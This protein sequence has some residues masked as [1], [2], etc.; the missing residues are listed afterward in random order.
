MGTLQSETKLKRLA[1]RFQ[2]QTNEACMRIHEAQQSLLQKDR[3][4]KAAERQMVGRRIHKAKSGVRRL[5]AFGNSRSL[6]QI[7]KA[8]DRLPGRGSGVLFSGIDWTWIGNK[9]MT[10]ISFIFQHDGMKIT[11]VNKCWVTCTKAY[12]LPYLGQEILFHVDYAGRTDIEK[13]ITLANFLRGISCQEA[14]NLAQLRESRLMDG[15]TEEE[16]IFQFLV[17]WSRKATFEKA[18]A[19]FLESLER[20]LRQES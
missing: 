20:R 17:S 9:P 5:L 15:P 19:H 16:V 2:A 8:N 14:I 13:K 4:R 6:Q 3:Q 18:T 11:S 1:T 7:V 12:T 10:E